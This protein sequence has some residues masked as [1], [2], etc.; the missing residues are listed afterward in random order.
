MSVT[1]AAPP[2]CA[3]SGAGPRLRLDALLQPRWM[4]PPKCPPY[5]AT[6]RR[7]LRTH[8]ASP[9]S[10]RQRRG[11]PG[12]RAP[13]ASEPT[14]FSGGCTYQSSRF[15]GPVPTRRLVAFGLGWHTV[16][17]NKPRTGLMP[18]GPRRVGRFGLL[19]DRYSCP[20]RLR[21]IERRQ[22]AFVPLTV[23][24]V[25]VV[26]LRVSAVPIFNDEGAGS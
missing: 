11:N 17:P 9:A 26:R 16:S 20:F 1:V 6:A 21:R 24:P 7:S 3:V 14:M 8:R 25:V 22:I 2:D 4:R 23:D 15:W 10:A 18:W 12:G 5:P 19:A 13:Q